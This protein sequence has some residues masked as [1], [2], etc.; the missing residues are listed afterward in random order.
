VAASQSQRSWAHL[1]DLQQEF[2]L[3]L[4][5]KP[6]CSAYAGYIK[7]G[8]SR[9][10]AGLCTSHRRHASR[11]N[12]EKL[13]WVAVSSLPAALSAKALADQGQQE[14][15][16]VPSA[17][18][19]AAKLQCCAELQ[20][21]LSDCQALVQE[22]MAASETLVQFLRELQNIA[23]RKLF[24]T[25]FQQQE[26]VEGSAREPP[27]A[28]AEA[29]AMPLP[30]FLEV[31]DDVRAIG[32]HKFTLLSENLEVLEYSTLDSHGRCHRLSVRWVAPGTPQVVADRVPDEAQ[33]W[34]DEGRTSLR[35]V[36]AHF[37][38]TVAA[39]QPFWSA[40]DDIDGRSWVLEPE[41]RSHACAHRRVL[42]DKHVSMVVE[43][44]PRDLLARGAG[45][46]VLPP[47]EVR[48][49]GL[50]ARVSALEDT[51]SRRQGDLWDA[52]RGIVDNIEAVLGLTLPSPEPGDL[53][54]SDPAGA[55][56]KEAMDRATGTCGICYSYELDTGGKRP[57]VPE[58][59][60]ENHRCTYLFHKECLV[61]WLQS[62]LSSRQAFNTY[63]GACPYCSEPVVCKL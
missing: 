21:L 34:P 31:A 37:E 2:P 63:F 62:D 14:E 52:G 51:W 3:V 17:G 24:F 12:A 10:G 46:A 11:G 44:K 8:D 42:L 60:C 20:D 35:D 1:S 38:E 49:L 36:V 32:A 6:D 55:D 7:C 39:L 25:S 23:E 28:D 9:L 59:A 47:V 13:L 43:L 29:L 27:K 40:L 15:G 30:H 22:R 45:E 50:A 26:A 53:N 16:C 41:D 56:G 57:A 58:M 19:C 54:P 4:P 61:E 5:V 48:F 33:V 18:L